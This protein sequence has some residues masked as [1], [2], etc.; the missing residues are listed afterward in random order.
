VEGVLTDDRVKE[1]HDAP[2]VAT[3]CEGRLPGVSL[4]G[5]TGTAKKDGGP[6]GIRTPDLVN[7]IHARSQ[8]RHWP[9]KEQS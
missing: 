9:G 6:E 3:L 2:P 7:A 4:A 1:F 8:L 5:R